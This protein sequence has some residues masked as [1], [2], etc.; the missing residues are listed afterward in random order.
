[1][2]GHSG[3]GNELIRTS[4]MTSGCEML[5]HAGFSAPLGTRGSTT[6]RFAAAQQ[7]ERNPL[8]PAFRARRNPKWPKPGSLLQLRPIDPALDR[9]HQGG[10]EGHGRPGVA[11]R[12]NLSA[13]EAPGSPGRLGHRF[14]LS[15]D[16]AEG[17]VSF[18]GRIRS[19]RPADYRPQIPTVS[20]EE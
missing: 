5:C 16:E 20:V 2:T 14:A 17:S 11:G 18:D 6:R 13:G 12:L 15:T 9:R 10:Q 3:L 8:A 19:R 1:M 4:S 7:D